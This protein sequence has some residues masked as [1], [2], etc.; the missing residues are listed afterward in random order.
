MP[1]LMRNVAQL[2]DPPREQVEVAVYR[3]LGLHRVGTI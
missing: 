1:K 3:I 2:V